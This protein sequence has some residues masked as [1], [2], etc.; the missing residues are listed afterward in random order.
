MSSRGMNKFTLI[1]LLV[2]IAIIAILA[3]MLLPALTKARQK[4]Q[5]TACKNNLKQI[6][7]SIQLYQNDFNDYT[8]IG[9]GTDFIKLSPWYILVQLNYLGEKKLFDC[10]GDTTRSPD[11]AGGYTAN[12]IWYD[13]VSKKYVNHSY[14][15]NQRCGLFYSLP[16]YFRQFRPC[17]DK[18]AYKIPLVYDAEWPATS[19][20]GMSYGV[21]DSYDSI[22][23]HQGANNILMAEGHVK[24][25]KRYF[26][27]AECKSSTGEIAYPERYN[28]YVTY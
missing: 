22:V 3:S 27:D 5:E 7:F 4:A 11:V 16:Q 8:V 19:S 1:E 15:Y 28:H 13:T 20:G 25:L 2:V 14:L 18:K 23:H 26:T 9:V 10:P 12:D 6:G 17:M 24:T 21:S